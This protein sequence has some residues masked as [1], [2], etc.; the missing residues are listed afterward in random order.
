MKLN[1]F[2]LGLVA[3]ACGLPTPPTDVEVDLGSIKEV[4]NVNNNNP[5]RGKASYTSETNTDINDIDVVVQIVKESPGVEVNHDFDHC[6]DYTE[7]FGYECVPYYLC[8]NGTIITDGSGLIDIRSS[9]GSLSAEDSKCPGY[10]DVCCKDPD[11]VAPKPREPIHVAKCGRRNSEGLLTRIQGFT[12]GESQFGEWP[13]MVAVLREDNV[14]GLNISLYECGGSL[15]AP[16]VILTAAHCVEKYRD[17]PTVLKVRAGEW[18]TQREVEPFLH[19]DRNV[20]AVRIHPEFNS[21][22][23]YNDFALLFTET[24]FNLSPHVD[25]VCLPELGE[26]FDYNTCFATGWGKDR[27]GAEGEYQ[28]VLKEIDLPIVDNNQCEDSLQKTRLGGRFRLHPSFMCAGG[29]AGKDTC[30]GDGGGPLV[31]PS[32]YDQDI[33]VQ[34]GVVAWGVGCGEDGTPGV[35]AAVSQAVCWIDYVMSWHYGAQS[36]DYSS[37]WG[38]SHSTCGN[39]MNNKVADLQAEINSGKNYLQ[40]VKDYYQEYQINWEKDEETEG[41]DLSGYG[42]S[43]DVE[44]SSSAV[45]FGR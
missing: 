41:P 21:G 35:Y 6:S 5:R 26:T 27:F 34:A 1:I 37:Y 28:V 32:K 39:W 31:C 12:S 20:A 8:K 13:H 23:L 30:K 3:T 16:G 7:Q 11:F 29:E 15:I 25:T 4:F 14:A 2:L 19:Q 24:I 33:Y 42:R 36:N 9:F 22:A 40:K 17:T 10:L 44:I 18:D 45:R 38:F 43:N